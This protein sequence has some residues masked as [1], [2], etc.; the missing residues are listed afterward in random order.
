MLNGNS[1]SYDEPSTTKK[2]YVQTQMQVEYFTISYLSGEQYMCQRNNFYQ[3]DKNGEWF[4]AWR[5][6]KMLYKI[7]E[8]NK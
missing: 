8:G 1:G 7:E 6:E 2:E 4:V 3:Q 5:S